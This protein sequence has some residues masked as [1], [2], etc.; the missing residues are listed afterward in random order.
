[1]SGLTGC[2][3]DQDPGRV[4]SGRVWSSSTCQE[5]HAGPI[6]GPFRRGPKVE[7][8]DR[9]QK[10]LSQCSH[11]SACV[12]TCHD[13]LTVVNESR[14]PESLA[15]RD[16]SEAVGCVVGNQ[17]EDQSVDGGGGGR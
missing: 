8:P 4:E 7:S 3:S 1:V 11:F 15:L 10:F 5:H 2:N 14:D 17:H 16:G 12:H 9:E 13:W 6:Y